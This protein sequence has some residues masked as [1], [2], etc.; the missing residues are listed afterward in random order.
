MLNSSVKKKKKNQQKIKFSE[1]LVLGY[2]A[3][4]L[5]KVPYVLSEISVVTAGKHQMTSLILSYVLCYDSMYHE[6]FEK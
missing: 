6:I 1:C 3:N 5:S 4:Y 2:F